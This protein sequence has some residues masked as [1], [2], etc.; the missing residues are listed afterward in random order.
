M[1]QKIGRENSKKKDISIIKRCI[2]VEE[3]QCNRYKCWEN[4]FL[5]LLGKIVTRI[6]DLIIASEGG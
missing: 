2:W 6:D 3:T 4:C 5:C 1:E